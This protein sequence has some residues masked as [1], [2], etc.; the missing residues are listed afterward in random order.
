M[1]SAGWNFLCAVIIDADESIPVGF[2]VISNRP[3]LPNQPK[4]ILC[5]KSHQFVEFQELLLC[6]E[7][8]SDISKKIIRFIFLA[9]NNPANG[10]KVEMSWASSEMQGA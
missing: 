9:V 1:V 10:W 5:E 4:A 2:S 3:L 8:E 6:I 7:L